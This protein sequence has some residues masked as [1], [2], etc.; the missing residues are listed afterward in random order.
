ML[1][2][3]RLAADRRIPGE[4]DFGGKVRA[5]SDWLH[6]HQRRYPQLRDAVHPFRVRATPKTPEELLALVPKTA[7]IL[8]EVRAEARA[9]CALLLC[10]PPAARPRLSHSRP[11][12][13][14]DDVPGGLCARVPELWAL[15]G[16]TA[17]GFE[18]PE[19]VLK[20]IERF[21]EAHADD[22]PELHAAVTALDSKH[23]AGERPAAAPDSSG[24]GRAGHIW[25]KTRSNAPSANAPILESGEGM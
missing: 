23:R 13:V 14:R 9:R 16:G 19:A 18:N 1:E 15:L 8:E 24:L 2:A 10:V 22:W 12:F 11:Q 17:S 7:D 4:P 25:K 3:S 5:A 20:W 6:R 21:L